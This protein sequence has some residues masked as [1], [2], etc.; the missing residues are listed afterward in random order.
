M[1]LAPRERFTEKG[2]QQHHMQLRGQTTHR[3]TNP[4]EEASSE[5]V[6]ELESR[7]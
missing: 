6:V 5:V 2:K 7:L 3:E 4:K 1:A